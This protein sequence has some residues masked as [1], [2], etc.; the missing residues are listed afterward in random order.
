M[1]HFPFEHIVHH[2]MEV[3]HKLHF[4]RESGKLDRP[5]GQNVIGGIPLV[6]FK[7]NSQSKLNCR[8]N[9][10]GHV[11]QHQKCPMLIFTAACAIRR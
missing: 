6:K 9:N 1:F 5:K 11:I 10:S 2:R 7:I 8:E 3:T 4:R